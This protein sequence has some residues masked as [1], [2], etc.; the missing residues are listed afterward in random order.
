MILAYLSKDVTTSLRAAGAL[1][2]IKTQQL[3]EKN[4]VS[5]QVDPNP[6]ATF[7]MNYNPNYPCYTLVQ[8]IIDK[9]QQ[10]CHFCKD[11]ELFFLKPFSEHPCVKMAWSEKVKAYFDEGCAAVGIVFSMPEDKMS[12][13]HT[14][15]VAS[16]PSAE[17]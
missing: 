8:W 4:E 6:A 1:S 16:L 12:L 7:L 14:V 9:S 15:L 13:Y 11:M 5:I 17:T 2:T 3:H 10:N